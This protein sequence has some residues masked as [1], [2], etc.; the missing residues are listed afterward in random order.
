MNRHCRG[1][2]LAGGT[3]SRLLP[4]T[5][6]TNKHLMPVGN[7]PMLQHAVEK[8]V[9]AGIPEIMV[10]TGTE[11][12]GD[13]FKFLGSGKDFGCEFTY[14]VQDKSGGIAEAIYLA[15]DFVKNDPFCTILGDNVFA[16]ELRQYVVRFRDYFNKIPT[17]APAGMLLI[18]EV[19][20]P[21]RFGVVKFND[22]GTINSVIEKP[23]EAPSKFAVTGLYFYI[24]KGI[25]DIIKSLRPS[26]RQELEITDLNN[27]LI[28]Q[29]HMSFSY[30]DGAWTD[31]GTFES[32]RKA[33]ELFS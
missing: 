12:S 30:L 24:G 22:N 20:D 19:E 16:A 27:E 13:I 33:N 31:S 9:Q 29:G 1:L 5:K 18:K 8:L 3:G 14:R 6:V 15:K 28:K 7:K 26:N 2:I 23:K 21:N 25:F 4:L 10:V 11:H 17:D 32:L